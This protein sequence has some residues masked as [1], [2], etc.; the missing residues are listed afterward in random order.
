[1]AK[2]KVTDAHGR[3]QYIPEHW[4]GHPELGKGFTPIS[5]RP[6]IDWTVDKLRAHAEAAG[7]DLAGARNKADI[8]DR[9]SNP[10]A[11]GDNHQN[12]E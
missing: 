12:Q 2:V 1:M 4:L 5:E 8:L 6:S 3:E 10:P 7:V 9:L 11:R